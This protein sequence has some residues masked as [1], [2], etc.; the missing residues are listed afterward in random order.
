MIILIGYP[1]IQ[2]VHLATY[3]LKVLL[4]VPPIHHDY[5]CDR[6]ITT[7]HWTPYILI[8]KGFKLNTVRKLE[9]I[10]SRGTYM[11]K[12]DLQKWQKWEVDS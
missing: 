7:F 9:I 6:Y 1:C 8:Y 10:Y 5:Y 3:R 2:T 12:L 11:F 4:A